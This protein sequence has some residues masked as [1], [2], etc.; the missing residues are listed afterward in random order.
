MVD[1]PCRGAKKVRGDADAQLYLDCFLSS[2]EDFC[3]QMQTVQKEKPDQFENFK[4]S[5]NDLVESDEQN[6]GDAICQWDKDVALLVLE[7][8]DKDPLMKV[9]KWL[10]D[11]DYFIF[12]EE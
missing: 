5:L 1:Q 2:F 10:S 7:A 8:L 12:E 6:V 3:E 11:N 9:M 4:T